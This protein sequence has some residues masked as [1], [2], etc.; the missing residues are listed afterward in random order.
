MPTKYQTHII[1]FCFCPIAFLFWLASAGIYV[2]Q[3]SQANLLVALL[4]Q[5]V[6]VCIFFGAFLVFM[7]LFMSYGFLLLIQIYGVEKLLQLTGNM[8][9]LFAWRELKHSLNSNQKTIWDSKKN[10][11]DRI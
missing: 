8:Y 3:V 4:F 10:S 9:K 7:C 6:F 1:L 5:I 2:S 11:D